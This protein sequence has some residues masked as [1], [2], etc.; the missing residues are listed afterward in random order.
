M[1]EEAKIIFSFNGIEVHIQCTL[2]DKIK[3]ICKKYATKIDNNIN[4]LL[5]LYGGNQ[6]NMELK[7]KEQ[8]SSIDI[9]NKEMNV[10]VYKNE[11]NDDFICP[12]CNKKIKLNTEKIDEI[13]LINNNIK[14]II[15]GIKFTIDNII[16]LSKDNN[17]SF[18]LKN[19]NIIVNTINEDINKNNDKLKKLLNENNKLNEINEVLNKEIKYDNGR[20][21]G[22]VVNG[23]MEGKGIYY[24]NDGDRYEGDFKNDKF[25]GKGICYCNDEPWKGDRYEGDFKNDKSEG[26]GI[27]YFKN[28]DRY[29][30]DWKNGKMEGKGIYYYNNGDRYEGDWKND[31]KEGKGIYYYK[32]GNRE[33]GD[34]KDDKEI[35]KHVIL[36]N[37]G[38]VKI[39]NY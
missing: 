6:M 37:N 16:K 29:E 35:G 17:I 32:N 11:N 24:C 21:V 22:Q 5:F 9:Y 12:N 8:A 27:Y 39:E 28:G 3:D 10:L 19:I 2:E 4:S 25:E 30:G 31:K 7:F 34:W 33:M 15:N 1:S 14:D 13:I 23:K 38:E 20:Y 26:K 36:Y 18:P